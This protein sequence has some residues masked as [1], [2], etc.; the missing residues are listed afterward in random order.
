LGGTKY[1]KH[2]DLQNVTFTDPVNFTEASFARTV[3]FTNCVFQQGLEISGARFEG[4]LRLDGSRFSPHK[5][6]TRALDAQ[7]MTVRRDLSARGLVADSQILFGGSQ[8]FGDV[9]LDGVSV[10]GDVRFERAD[11]RGALFVRAL[12]PGHEFAGNRSPEELRPQIAASLSCRG[13]KGVLIR[14]A[15]AVVGEQMRLDGADLSEGLYCES[16]PAPT[17][18]TGHVN[19]H[20]LR[21]GEVIL[22]GAEFGAGMNL[23]GSRIVGVCLLKGTRVTGDLQMVR[24]SV[25]RELFARPLEGAVGT[26]GDGA[27]PGARR[28]E[29]VGRFNLFGTE[30]GGELSLRGI[31]VT[32]E[33]NLGLAEVGEALKIIPEHGFQP[34]L[35]SLDLHGAK[36]TAGVQLRGAIVKDEAR[37]GHANIGVGLSLR[38]VDG[39]RTVIRGRLS[40]FATKVRGELD[41]RGIEVHGH[42]S[43]TRCECAEVMGSPIDGHRTTVE[44]VGNFSLAKIEGTVDLC[45][46]RFGQDLWVTGVTIGESLLLAPAEGHRTEVGTP[47]AAPGA[48]SR[49]KVFSIAGSKIANRVDLRGALFHAGCNLTRA[50]FAEL[51]A[52]PTNDAG[53]LPA[54]V[55]TEIGGDLD[56]SESQVAGS[57]FLGGAVVAGTLWMWQTKVAADVSLHNDPEFAFTAG[58]DVTL[59]GTQIGA[60]LHLSTAAC[61]SFRLTNATV[62]GDLLVSEISSP[63]T[64]NKS[65]FVR[66]ATIVRALLIHRFEVGEFDCSNSAIGTDLKLG[67]ALIPDDAV[68]HIRAGGAVSRCR[69][70]GDVVVHRVTVARKLWLDH[71][72]VGRHVHFFDYRTARGEIVPSRVTDGLS[73]RGTTIEGDLHLEG[74]RIGRELDLRHAKIGTELTLLPYPPAGEHPATVGGD[75]L[76]EAARVHVARIDGRVCAGATDLSLGVFTQLVFEN[77]L[78][79]RVTTEGVQFQQL[80]IPGDDYLGFLERCAFHKSIYRRVEEWLRNRGEDALANQ[81]YIT[82]CRKDRQ[83]GKRLGWFWPGLQDWFSRKADWLVDCGVGY[84]VYWLRPLLVFVSLFVFTAVVFSRP[85]SSRRPLALTSTDVG[86][87]RQEPVNVFPDASQWCWRDGTLMAFRTTVPFSGGLGTPQ[88]VPSEEHVPWLALRYSTF[89]VFAT[90]AGWILVPLFLA[91]MAGFI[92]KQK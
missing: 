52:T 27:R 53:R 2:L 63:F 62:G 11:V 91:G 77:R 80:R 21:A 49:P 29:V 73:L 28:T 88:W 1:T 65:F 86:K 6:Y 51:T 70:G 15:G 58:K 37:L 87:G 14:L 3:K 25:G 76:F 35:G 24:A 50:T 9:T 59:T 5:K 42:L 40:L 36:V 20:G 90:V 83:T 67:S 7:Q 54:R 82:M 75:I 60:T 8:L 32:N 46:A 34:E 74:V 78:P 43:L 71:N 17:H 31:H 12:P 45:G 26:G 61:A 85:E 18:I 39:H 23:S 38:P 55:R 92:K 79:N 13:M 72:R 10:R 69:V 66:D 33:L 16:G 81:V 64:A 56:L 19:L 84:G 44:G 68:S 89:A 48:E 30:V 22:V 57:V 4:H 41:L 47:P